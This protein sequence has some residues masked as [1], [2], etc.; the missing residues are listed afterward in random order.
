MAQLLGFDTGG[1]EAGGGPSQF[2]RGAVNDYAC[3]GGDAQTV[4][5]DVPAVRKALHVPLD[6]LFFNG[7][8]GEA[9]GS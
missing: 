6:A 8:D 4:W 5:T 7:D 2:V 1:A 3:G 9:C